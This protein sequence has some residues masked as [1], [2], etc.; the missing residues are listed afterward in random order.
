MILAS[1]SAFSHHFPF[2]AFPLG[3]HGL[4]EGVSGF[5]MMS[6]IALVIL[7]GGPAIVLVV[8][9]LMPKLLERTARQAKDNPLRSFLWGL[10]LVFILLVLIKILGAIILFKILSLL[11]LFFTIA[12]LIFGFSACALLVADS[13]ASMKGKG[14]EL[15]S[16]NNLLLGAFLLL[17]GSL[18]PFAG[19]VFLGFICTTGLG[20]FV[21]LG[22]HQ[23]AS[24][25]K[26]KK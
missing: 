24:M 25:D 18:V 17:L 20:A 9:S 15:S 4:R 10:L 1:L 14:K 6:F 16:F 5:F 11:V 8:N 2:W 7:V 19:V 13:I 12:G 21:A 3:E 22:I 26:K 23:E